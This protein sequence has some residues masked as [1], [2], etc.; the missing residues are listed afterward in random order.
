MSVLIERHDNIATA[1]LNRAEK[2]NAPNEAM[3]AQLT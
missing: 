2:R 3:Y 1:T